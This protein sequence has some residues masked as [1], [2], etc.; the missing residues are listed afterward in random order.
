M[1]YSCTW[2]H[3]S[4]KRVAYI[5]IDLT[6]LR[7]LH[8]GGI[9]YSKFMLRYLLCR[10]KFEICY[11]FS[12]ENDVTLQTFFSSAD[13]HL[14]RLRQY[15][16]LHLPDCRS[17]SFCHSGLFVE[18]LLSSYLIFTPSNCSPSA[19]NLSVCPSIFHIRF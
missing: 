7:G 16:S 9:D 10:L 1:F 14:V 3:I 13:C 8:D 11:T 4:A 5:C 19:Q 15:H 18:S 12:T 17:M 2:S 6:S